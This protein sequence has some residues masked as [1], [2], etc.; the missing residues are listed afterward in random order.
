MFSDDD[1]VPPTP[2]AGRYVC[3][4]CGRPGSP[5]GFTRVDGRYATGRCSGK[6][7]G[8]QFLIREDLYGSTTEKKR[9]KRAPDRPR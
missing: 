8:P 4:Q 2:P 9:R 1:L 5:D 3:V 7:V 6:H